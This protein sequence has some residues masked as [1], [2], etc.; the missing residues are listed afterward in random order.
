M[1]RT[2]YNL[3]LYGEVSRLE[4]VLI[5]ALYSTLKEKFSFLSISDFNFLYSP[6]IHYLT[7]SCYEY[8]QDSS[9][10]LHISAQEKYLSFTP[11]DSYAFY[12]FTRHDDFPH[13]LK[14]IMTGNISSNQ[15]IRTTQDTI[16][17]KHKYLLANTLAYKSGFSRSF[18][19]RLRISSRFRISFIKTG[20]SIMPMEMNSSERE[21]LMNRIEKTLSDNDVAY[22][23][24]WATLLTIFLPQSLFESLKSNFSFSGDYENI[25][26]IFSCNAWIFEDSWKL[27]GLFC[28][29]KFGTLLIG[30]PHAVAHGALEFSWQREFEI[31]HL[32][33]YLTWG[34]KSQ[35]SNVI[36]FY[37][38]M[39]S[40]IKNTKKYQRKQRMDSIVLTTAARPKHT[41]EYPYES[42]IYQEYLQEQINIIKALNSNF[43][44]KVFV[45]TRENQMGWN[46]Q[47]LYSQNNLKVVIDKQ[48]GN[49]VEALKNFDLHISDN[50][51]TAYLESLSVNWPTMII[52]SSSYFIFNEEGGKDYLLLK[53]VGIYHDSIDSL[54]QQLSKVSLHIGDWWSSELVQ[55]AIKTF[56]KRQGRHTQATGEWVSV[57][58]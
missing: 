53:D 31:K 3:K 39:H 15:Y 49:F 20:E 23:K 22:G 47:E 51:S 30:S 48:V 4:Q 27:F 32:D 45:R 9:F 36:D 57:L 16:K 50:C 33:C 19:S 29:Q 14:G 17:V 56:L 21:S 37:S 5:Q 52:N 18:R 7:H 54:M 11:G 10:T 24:E 26:K 6:F 41:L 34:W 40:G 1:S 28:R 42:Q 13:I 46:I 12:Q 38:P 55:N 58:T 35:N 43:S 2:Q 25:K 44:L 8:V